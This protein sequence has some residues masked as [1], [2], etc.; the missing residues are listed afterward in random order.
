MLGNKKERGVRFDVNPVQ[1]IWN[2]VTPFK[3]AFGEDLEPWHKELIRLGAPLKE[4]RDKKKIN[5]V[6]LDPIQRG[7][8]TNI[9]K[10]QIALPLQIMTQRGLAS[11]GAGDISVP[12]LSQGADVSPGVCLS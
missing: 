8:L 5:G 3:V 2:S 4:S 12:R 9:A 7:E 1:A 6:T 11:A 10:N